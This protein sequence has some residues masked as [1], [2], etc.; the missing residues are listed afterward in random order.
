MVLPLFF[1]YQDEDS[2]AKEISAQEREAMT[3]RKTTLLRQATRLTL[4]SKA[5]AH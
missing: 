2:Q 1:S 3:K 4:S 5:A